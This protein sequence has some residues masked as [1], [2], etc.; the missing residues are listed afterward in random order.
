MHAYFHSFKDTPL[1]SLSHINKGKSPLEMEHSCV[2]W[3]CRQFVKTCP[4]NVTNRLSIKKIKYLINVS[5]RELLVCKGFSHREL[6]ILPKTRYLY[7]PTSL[8]NPKV[9]ISQANK[10]NLKCHRMSWWNY[11]NTWLSPVK[12]N[13]SHAYI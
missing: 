4:P 13:L 5:F 12:I 8:E 2:S 3:E 1:W 11:I 7:I 9:F 6:F 10:V